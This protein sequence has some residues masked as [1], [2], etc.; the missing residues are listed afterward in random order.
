MLHVHSIPVRQGPISIQVPC[1]PCILL[2]KLFLMTKH[3]RTVEIRLNNVMIPS[4][5][6]RVQKCR[7]V[8]AVQWKVSTYF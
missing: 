6:S 2:Q 3:G 8:V 4:F 7:V 5:D 1:L